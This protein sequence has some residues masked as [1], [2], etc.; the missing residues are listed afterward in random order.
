MNART[1]AVVAVVVVVAAALYYW[2]PTLSVGLQS[3]QNAPQE[4]QMSGEKGPDPRVSMVGTWKARYESKFTRTFYADGR[5][6]DTYEGNDSATVSGDWEVI[7]HRFADGTGWSLGLANIETLGNVPVAALEGKTV[8][9][10][11]WQTPTVV[12]TVYFVLNEGFSATSMT[13]IN[14]SGTGS[15]AFVKIN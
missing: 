3:T 14:L 9:K 10:T 12:D 7:K 15:T 8:V 13:M 5:V 6:M 4:Q 2:W 1:G 11:T